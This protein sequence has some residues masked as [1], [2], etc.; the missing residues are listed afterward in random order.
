MRGQDAET[1]ESDKRSKGDGCGNKKPKQFIYV[2]GSKCTGLQSKKGRDTTMHDDMKAPSKSNGRWAMRR[3]WGVEGQRQHKPLA[4]EL[5]MAVDGDKRRAS[6]GK[7]ML[8]EESER[9]G[10]G[11]PCR[12]GVARKRLS[13][14][15]KRRRG[16]HTRDFYS[17]ND[18]GT[19]LPQKAKLEYKA[20]GAQA[21][22]GTGSSG[23]FWF[24]SRQVTCQVTRQRAPPATPSRRGTYFDAPSTTVSIVQPILPLLLSH[25]AERADIILMDEHR[26]VDAGRTGSRRWIRD[27]M[28]GWCGGQWWLWKHNDRAEN[29]DD[30]HRAVAGGGVAGWQDLA[31]H[32]GVAWWWVGS[33]GLACHGGE[34]KQLQH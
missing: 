6:E 25:R 22:P 19:R 13:K 28:S 5:L 32:I 11:A 20:V 31:C 34:E 3:A 33:R 1:I 30:S 16:R 24:S 23:L 18:T 10:E 29:G 27:T 2:K 12:D 17:F 4:K 15:N 7:E 21:S 26:I 9:E 8:S 14:G